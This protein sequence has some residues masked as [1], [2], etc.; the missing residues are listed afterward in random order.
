MRRSHLTFRGSRKHGLA[1]PAWPRSCPLDLR[2]RSPCRGAPRGHTLGDMGNTLRPPIVWGAASAAA[3]AICLT[4]ATGVA[5]AAPV[6]WDG[7]VASVITDAQQRVAALSPKRVNRWFD[8]PAAAEVE[9]G[10]AAVNALPTVKDPSSAQDLGRLQVI[11]SVSWPGRQGVAASMYLRYRDGQFRGYRAV[12]DIFIGSFGF[13]K[14][15]T[16]LVWTIRRSQKW[17]TNHPGRIPSTY[18]LDSAQLQKADA[19]PP[20]TN[21]LRWVVTFAD[22][23][24][25]RQVLVYMDGC[26]E[27]GGRA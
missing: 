11:Y 12:D 7:D 8:M 25:A 20:L 17:A 13:R 19:P 16:D 24:L 4:P 26:I 9:L 6:A 15:R 27:Y 23:A 5:A 10:K 21:R 2:D 3:I 22:G 14:P 18:S 1:V